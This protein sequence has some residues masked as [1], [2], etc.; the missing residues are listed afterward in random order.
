MTIGTEFVPQTINPSD[1]PQFPSTT[2][3]L[4]KAVPANYDALQAIVNHGDHP[5]LTWAK[6][7]SFPIP[8]SPFQSIPSDLQAVS[9]SY[10]SCILAEESN[11]TSFNFNTS[12]TQTVSKETTETLSGTLGIK[13]KGFEASVTGT[14]SVEHTVTSTKDT[15]I[16]QSYKFTEPAN[17]IYVVW[18]LRM[19]MGITGA[20]KETLFAYD[21]I[22]KENSPG[23]PNKF[24]GDGA[25]AISFNAA[26]NWIDLPV[27]RPALMVYDS[28]GK[29]LNRP[30]S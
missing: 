21:G 11:V 22:I 26:R 15:E 28:S 4:Y 5:T 14:Y 13:A 16:D 17:R 19:R 20:D 2:P 8:T 1:Y 7:Y 10:W 18:Q 24:H 27:D 12:V 23:F 9:Y 25:R 30:E 29:A 3:Q 6:E